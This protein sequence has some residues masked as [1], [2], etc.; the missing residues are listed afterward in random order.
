MS[1]RT[2]RPSVTNTTPSTPLGD[3]GRDV[4]NDLFAQNTDVVLGP[5]F[6]GIVHSVFAVTA[7]SINADY[8]LVELAIQPLGR[9]KDAAS[10]LDALDKAQS[11][12]RT[13]HRLLVNMQL[14]YEKVK[15]EVASALGALRDSATKSLIDK[16]DDDLPAFDESDAKSKKAKVRT[17]AITNADV[18]AEMA[19]IFPKDMSALRDRQA[20]AKGA[21][22]H[23]EFMTDLV[24]SRIRSLEVMVSAAR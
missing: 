9:Q 18:E 24:K 16:G 6:D 2:H 20:K 13:A 17:K 8:Q 19:R 15:G 4:T 3:A 1:A 11:A 5:E 12:A 22:D 7:A 14:I 21:V 10:I 23:V